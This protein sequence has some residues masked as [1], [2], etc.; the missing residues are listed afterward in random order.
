M[1]LDEENDESNETME[2]T[3]EEEL[4]EEIEIPENLRPRDHINQILRLDMNN[5][6]REAAVER[7]AGIVLKD[8][9]KLYDTAIQPLE[10]LFKYRDLSNRHFG[11]PEI[12]SKP[13]ILFMG[14]WSGGK[15]SIINYLLDN[16]YKPTALR[17]GT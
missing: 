6:D 11:D 7:A 8:L 9:K 1:I 4:I 14:P 15:S 17:T 3:P 5:E 10:T 2:S 12:F 16:E 13:L